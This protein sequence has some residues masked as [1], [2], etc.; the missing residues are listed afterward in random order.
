MKNIDLIA[1]KIEAY[2]SDDFLKTL[3]AN[4]LTYIVFLFNP[5]SGYR[6]V[7]NVVSTSKK[8]TILLTGGI[9]RQFHW[10]IY[11]ILYPVTFIVDYF[12]LAFKINKFIKKFSPRNGFVDNTF[13]AFHFAY[14]RKKSKIDNLVY[15]SHDWFQIDKESFNISNFLK[16]CFSYLFLKFD[17][18]V[19]QNADI[20][21]NHT[22][23]VKENRSNYWN[24][25]IIKGKEYFYKPPLSPIF[26]RSQNKPKI[27]NKIVFLGWATKSSGL[28][29]ILNA[30]NQSEYQLYAIGKENETIKHILGLSNFKNF[31]HLGFLERSKFD[32]IFNESIAGINLI[33][34]KNVHT[35]HTIPSKIIDYLRYGV[36]IICTNNIGPFAEVILKYKLGV[37]ISPTKH[38]II[39]AIE[40]ISLNQE[41]YSK[42][43]RF[44]FK[45]FPFS[46]LLKYFKV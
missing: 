8:R 27:K 41:D 17:Y 19:C 32:N 13:T 31:N 46:N 43:I 20:V 7:S 35:V 39:E 34:S 22:K 18:F 11:A 5:A 24:K 21:L 37:I 44:F 14:L 36:P 33:T 3:S 6:I 26:D 30:I 15:A 16:S 1:Y 9:T 28:N 38:E 10:I 23:I 4:N 12:V 25:N 45:D 2:D 42:N 40:N 29:E